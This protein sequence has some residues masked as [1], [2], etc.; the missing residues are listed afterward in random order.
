M[1]IAISREPLEL[2][3]RMLLNCQCRLSNE[4][5][6]ALFS[7]LAAQNPGAILDCREL[8]AIFKPHDKTPTHRLV[9]F[10]VWMAPAGTREMVIERGHVLRHFASSYHWEH[11]VASSLPTTYKKVASIQTC[12]LS[13]MLLPIALERMAKGEVHGLYHIAFREDDSRVRTGHGQEDPAMLRRLALNLIKRD[14]HRRIGVKASRKR[15]GW[16]LDCHKRLLGLE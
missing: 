2:T 10:S 9:H 7:F 13:R 3:F 8:V 14:P 16:D 12:F 15:A 4:Q 6:W 5:E 11:V 1:W